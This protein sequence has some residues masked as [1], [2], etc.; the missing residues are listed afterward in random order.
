MAISGA[1]G[2]HEATPR[3]FKRH[4]AARQDLGSELLS[5]GRRQRGEAKRCSHG[6]VRMGDV[7]GEASEPLREED[8]AHL[9]AIA[10]NGAN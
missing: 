1:S 6:M 10:N 2:A 5:G 3:S 7:Q 8:V 4:H 9:A